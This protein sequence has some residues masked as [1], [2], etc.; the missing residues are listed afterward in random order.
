MCLNKSSSYRVPGV[1]H[2]LLD[3][4]WLDRWDDSSVKT[5]PHHSSNVVAWCS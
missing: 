4:H 5:V 3:L 2:T 1:R